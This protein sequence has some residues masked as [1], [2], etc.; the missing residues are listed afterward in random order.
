[1]VIHAATV[2]NKGREDDDGFTAHRRWKG[3]ELTRPVADFGECVMCLPAASV[4]K[5]KFDVRWEDGAWLGIEMES[6]ESI[7]GTARGVVKARNFR[8]KPEEGGRWSN[9]CIDGFNGVP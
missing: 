1:M 3:R 6:G 5:N 8:R 2:I 7:I 4:G 9:D